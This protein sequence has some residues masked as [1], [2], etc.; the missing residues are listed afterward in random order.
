[1]PWSEILK[2]VAYLIWPFL[3]LGF[4]YLVK[5]RKQLLRRLKKVNNTDA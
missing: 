1:M 2:I 3:L 4:Y 5:N